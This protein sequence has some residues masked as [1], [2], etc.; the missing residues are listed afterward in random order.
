MPRIMISNDPVTQLAIIFRDNLGQDWEVLECPEEAMFGVPKGTVTGLLRQIHKKNLWARLYEVAQ[1]HS[2]QW[3]ID[4]SCFFP[5]EEAFIEPL[6]GMFLLSKTEHAQVVFAQEMDGW[7]WGPNT[8]HLLPCAIVRIRAIRED[9]QGG[10]FSPVIPTL[11]GVIKSLS[12]L[13]SSP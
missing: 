5:P 6:L 12:E 13:N 1:Q 10:D 4:L 8:W 9:I 3:L 11:D 2:E 7:P